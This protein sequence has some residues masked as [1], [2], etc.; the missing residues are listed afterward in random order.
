MRGEW[1]VLKSHKLSNQMLVVTTMIEPFEV[2]YKTWNSDA[3]SAF[4]KISH[5]A[6][7][8]LIDEINMK[9]RLNSKLQI[10]TICSIEVDS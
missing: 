9:N 2:F 7:R 4:S 5:F 8:I 3:I 10:H 6:E 1:R